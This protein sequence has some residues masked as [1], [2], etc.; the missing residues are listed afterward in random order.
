MTR[1]RD[2]WTD[3]TNLEREVFFTSLR[4]SPDGRAKFDGCATCHEVQ[5]NGLSAPVITRP[6]LP[7]RQRLSS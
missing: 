5:A 4:R 1:L 2:Q 7:D 6:A 3:G